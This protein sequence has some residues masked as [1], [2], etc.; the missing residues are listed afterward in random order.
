MRSNT[1]FEKGLCER[2]G[3]FSLSKGQTD[4]FL[5]LQANTITYQQLALCKIHGNTEAAGRLSLKRLEKQG[6]VRSKK[7]PDT[8]A[9]KYYFLTTSG[10]SFLK[11]LFPGAFLEEM[12]ANWERRPPGGI[13]QILHRIRTNDFYFTYIGSCLS[14]PLPWIIEA[15]LPDHGCPGQGMPPRCDGLLLSPGSKYYIEQDNSTQSESVI[16]KKISLYQQSGLL[17]GRQPRNLLVFCLAFPRKQPPAVKPSFSL[18]RILLHFTRLWGLFEQEYQMPLDYQQF[19]QVLESSPIQKTVSANEMQALQTLRALHPDMDTLADADRLKKG[20]LNDSSYSE[21]KDQ[22]MDQ[23]FLKRRRSHF[24]RIYENYPSLL[25]YALTGVPIFAVPNHRLCL[26]QPYIMPREY[27]L[28]DQLLKCLLFNGL[29]TD[30]WVYCCPL[31]VR[32][33]GRPDFYFYQGVFHASYGYIAI[34]HLLIDLSARYRLIH[35]IKNC[36]RQERPVFLIL[37]SMDP[38]ASEIRKQ[39]DTASEYNS[40]NNTV[41]LQINANTSMY[42]D[43]PPQIFTSAPEKQAVRFECDEFDGKIRFIRKEAGYAGF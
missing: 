3:L 1:T 34:E 18:Y 40:G 19:I 27:H 12:Q 14:R 4:L 16:L 10:R 7:I 25:A 9:A 39:L 23:L 22:E 17:S 29:N 11:Q 20:Y 26:Y 8:G 36:R 41:L 13:Q 43:P 42:Q 6:Y 21:L 2:A 32:V 28:S 35:Y 31:R 33:S 37:V 24:R 5:L 30:G 38:E 15:P